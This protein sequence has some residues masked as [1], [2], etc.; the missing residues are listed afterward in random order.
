MSSLKIGHKII[1]VN[2]ILNNSEPTVYTILD[3]NP[4]NEFGHFLFQWQSS[5]SITCSTWSCNVSH[6]EN[7][8]RDGHVKILN[9][10]ICFKPIP[11]FNFVK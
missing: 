6:M 3:I 2:Q 8:V 7:L 10:E 11:K 5:F 9:P 1:W 4:N